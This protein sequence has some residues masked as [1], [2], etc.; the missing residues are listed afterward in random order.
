MDKVLVS[1]GIPSVEMS[2]D[3]YLPINKKVGTIKK[4]LLNAIHE[5]TE[6][7]INITL[8]KMM[9]I[10]KVTGKEHENDVYVKDS[11][12]KNGTSIIIL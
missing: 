12:I 5:L 11:G 7:Q 2:F 8:E 3:V 4:Y 9:L 1:V 10:D 6:N